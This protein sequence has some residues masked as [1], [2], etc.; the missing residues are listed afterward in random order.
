MKYNTGF[1]ITLDV[2]ETFLDGGI[3]SLMLASWKK[4]FTQ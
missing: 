3:Y 2:N 4:Y 1:I